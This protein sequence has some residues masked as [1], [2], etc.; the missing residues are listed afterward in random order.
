MLAAERKR[1]IVEYVRQ[2]RTA[3]VAA[4]AQEFG[5]HG[6]TIRR[7]L[8]EIEQEGVLKRT[9]GGVIMEQWT[10]DEPSFYDRRN[11]H[12]EEKMR[13]GR[14]AASLVEDGENIIIDSG[15][16][17]LHIATHLVGRSDITVV[18]NDMNVAV[19]LR[20]A[21]GIKV[22]LTGGELYP[23][24]YMLNGMFTDHV[25]KSLHVEKAFIGTPALHP[26]HG[27]MH[28]EAL[29]VPAKQGMIAAAG[30][31]IVVTDHTKIGK[32]SLHTVAPNS[33]I[34]TLITG[35]EASEYDV[36][37]FQERGITVYRV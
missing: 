7:D 21:P 9:H 36:K 29:L 34:H 33:A 5:V 22:I 20:D 27:L 14:R 31:I 6:A 2:Y 24:S 32:L 35:T 18:T 28:P 1:R 13:I 12:L 17:T 3:T 15:T 37:P 25:L 26:Q 19:E 11:Q 10:H 4:L 16:T 23:S 30:E 8:A